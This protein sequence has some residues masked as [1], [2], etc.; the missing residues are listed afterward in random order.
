MTEQNHTS[1]KDLPEIIP[2]FPLNGVILLPQTTLPLNIF[3]PRYLAMVDDALAR[4][5][6]IG[7]VQPKPETADRA[8]PEMYRTGGLGRITSFSETE[9]GRYIISLAGVAKFSIER[10]LVC[11]TPY[12]QAE[13]SYTQFADE[14]RASGEQMNVDRDKLMQALKVYLQ[15]NNMDTD[16][17]SISSAPS[18]TLINSLAMICPFD[19]TEK[20][21]LL[22][23]PNVRDRCEILSALLQMASSSGGE[24]TSIQ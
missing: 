7:M 24:G 17:D 1:T 2:V 20:Q 16:W 23:A 19:A 18:D 8:R 21:A 9:D 14:L 11:D 22:E 12:R 5:R 13:V 4:K 3:E 10:E 15:A 6:F